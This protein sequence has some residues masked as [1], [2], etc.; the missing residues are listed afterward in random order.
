MNSDRRLP[1]NPLTFI[2]HCVRQRSIRWTYHVNM[3]LKG[4][5]ISR[6]TIL[7]AVNSYEIIESYPEDKYLPSYL[8][9]ASYENQILHTLFATDTENQNVR[10]VTA[11]FPD[12]DEWEADFK[13]RRYVT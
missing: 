7:N 12:P 3:R 10:I 13:T 11:Y 8:I 6:H 2:Q 4:R 5:S 1:E 9:H